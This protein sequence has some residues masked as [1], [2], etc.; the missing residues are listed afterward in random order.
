MPAFSG[1]F[2]FEKVRKKKKKKDREGEPKM[3]T[4]TSTEHRTP[5][6]YAFLKRPFLRCK[7]EGEM[8]YKY[9]EKNMKEHDAKPKVINTAPSKAYL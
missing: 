8:G 5:S 2:L 6:S 3:M 4:V 9:R 7:R 1:G